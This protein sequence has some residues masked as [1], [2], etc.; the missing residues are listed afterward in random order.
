MDIGIIGSG[1]V[2]TVL[3]AGFVARG[4]KVVLGSRQPDRPELIEWRDA[5]GERASTGTNEEAARFG[6]MVVFCP[7]WSGARGAL[8]L[9]GP[10]NFSGKVVIDVTNPIGTD[11][12]GRLVLAV[13]CDSSAAEQ[14][15]S[16]VPDARVVK[17]FN[18]VGSASM[19]KPA[20][21]SGP[22][23]GFLCGD[24]EDA[25]A[26]VAG[27]LRDFGWDPVDMGALIAARG[28]EPMVLNWMAYGTSTG[29]WDHA[30]TVVRKA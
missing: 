23:A 27:V 28:L 29:H 8:D 24:D 30:F 4:D 14:L 7:R 15:Q 18:W 21:P 3:G 26:L 12:Q 2:G 17:A 9:A 5:A 1:M 16:W 10:E 20:F 13:G 11:E 22:A 19:V 6:E 25:K